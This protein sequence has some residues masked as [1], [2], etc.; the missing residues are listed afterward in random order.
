MI[1]TLETTMSKLANSDE[2]NLHVNEVVMDNYRVII[3]I[4]FVYTFLNVKKIIKK[5]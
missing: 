2:K 4:V 3:S 1:L 5:I